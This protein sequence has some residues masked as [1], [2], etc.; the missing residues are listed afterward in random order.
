MGDSVAA[1]ARGRLLPTTTPAHCQPMEHRARAARR[2][3][4]ASGRTTISARILA[5]T[6][7]SAPARHLLRAPLAVRVMP[8]TGYRA[9][10]SEPAD[11]P[12]QPDARRAGPAS[13]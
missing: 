9:A 6:T 12:G 1:V 3:A 4:A 10:G 7:Q 8:D 11:P 13:A 2:L 5:R